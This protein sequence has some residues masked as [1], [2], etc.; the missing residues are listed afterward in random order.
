M[1]EFSDIK[2]FT[3]DLDGVITDTAKFHEQAW[4]DLAMQIGVN[5]SDE[6]GNQLKGI[7]RMD[8]LNMILSAAGQ[9]DKY[10]DEEKQAF[11]IQ[12]NTHYV[13]LIQEI[14]PKDILPGMTAFLSEIK[15]GGYIA[16]IASASKNAPKILEKLG[17]IDDFVGIVDPATLSHGKPDP[18][19]FTKAGD[20]LKLSPSQ[21]IGLEDAS[22]GVEAIKAAGQ[23]ALG[24]GLAAKSASPNLW[25]AST[26]EISLANIAAGMQNSN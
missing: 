12:K 15:S 21:I 8:S 5:W 22:A 19:I 3:F 25:V 13:E 2:G 20:I 16:S 14:T 18:E 26:T 24:I 4:H 23:T 6:L 7:S 1:V 11:T 10:S 9:Q 17:I